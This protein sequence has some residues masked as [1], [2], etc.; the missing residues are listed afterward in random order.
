MNPLTIM[1]EREAE[2]E[3]A[4]DRLAWLVMA[5]GLLVIVAWRSFV[6]GQP[7]W[8]LLALVIAGGAVSFGYRIWHRAVS[9]TTLLGVGITIAVAI[10]LAAVLAI[11][12]PTGR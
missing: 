8:E 7:S 6:D 2:I 11:A 3:H 1:D 9:R 5:Y 12:G 4:G 10:V